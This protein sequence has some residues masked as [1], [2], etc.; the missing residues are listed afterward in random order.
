[1]TCTKAQ[2]LALLSMLTKKI[3]TKCNDVECALDI[4]ENVRENIEELAQGEIIRE[5]GLSL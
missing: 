1:M 2:L 4:I 3:A 5:L